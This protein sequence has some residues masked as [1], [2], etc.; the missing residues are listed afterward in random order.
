V[1]HRIG[2]DGPSLAYE[3]LEGGE[4]TI[5]LLHGNSS[6]RGIWRWVAAELPEFRR[7]LLD[8]RGHGESDWVDPPAYDPADEAV[9][10]ARVVHAVVEGPY[11]L[12]GH[13]N[14]ALAAAAFVA[15][16]YDA[17]KPVA[18]IWGDI[19]P[20]VPEWQVEFFHSAA[21]RIARVYASAADAAAGFRRTYPNIPEERLRPFVEAGL[22]PVEGGL[23]MRLDPQVY[24]TFAPGDLRPLLSQIDLPVL[25]L[26]GGES[27]VLTDAGV[28][29]LTAGLRRCEVSI[30]ERA[31]HMMMLER[32]ELV[33]AAIRSFV[34]A[35]R[36]QEERVGDRRRS[37]G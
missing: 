32:P 21:G 7:V 12:L 6:H 29:D 19:D 33:A 4:P 2:G 18:L 34:Q 24:A 28:A 1:T 3:I 31:S 13:S 30:V 9:D 23:Q 36:N 26:R 8:V 25:V 22:R 37:D 27:I 35:G 15:G 11:V 14:G 5:V 10:I 20:R 17:P 16:D